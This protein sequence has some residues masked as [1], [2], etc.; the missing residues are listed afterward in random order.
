MNASYDALFGAL[1]GLAPNM[2]DAA[3]KANHALHDEYRPGE[4]D[5]T[6]RH[7][8]AFTICATCRELQQCREWVEGLRPSQRPSGVVAGRLYTAPTTRKRK[9]A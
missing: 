2:P 4:V 9:S 8:A 3:C 1:H 5:A 7:A 6:E